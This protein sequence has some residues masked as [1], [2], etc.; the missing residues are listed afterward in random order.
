[1]G[2]IVAIRRNGFGV[3]AYVGLERFLLARVF[4]RGAPCIAQRSNRFLMIPLQ[5]PRPLLAIW[6]ST[7]WA[8]SACRCVVG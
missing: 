3:P 4:C 6:C 1:M 7:Y 5:W 2:A 8:N